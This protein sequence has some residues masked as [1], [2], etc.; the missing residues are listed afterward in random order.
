MA[1]AADLLLLY[2]CY[3]VMIAAAVYPGYRSMCADDESMREKRIK[4][5]AL[6]LLP[7]FLSAAVDTDTLA[8]R[9]VSKDR[10]VRFLYTEGVRNTC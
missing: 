7:L 4:A 6:V 10:S 5:T 3:C 2:L 8:V 1:V 9:V